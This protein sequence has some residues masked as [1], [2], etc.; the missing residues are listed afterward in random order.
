MGGLAAFWV[1]TFMDRSDVEKRSFRQAGI[2]AARAQLAQGAGFLVLST[3]TDDR[4]GR[5]AAGR[6]FARLGLV[7]V[8]RGIGLHPM[9]QALEEPAWR[10]QV[11][12]SIGVSGTPQLLIRLGYRAY[13]DTTPGPRRGVEEIAA[14]E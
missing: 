13:P 10:E 12:G 4:R 6:A 8:S 11:A 9:S 1:R 2:Q 3:P 7:A 14:M 5:L